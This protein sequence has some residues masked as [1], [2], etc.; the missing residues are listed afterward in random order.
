M[1]HSSSFSLPPPVSR[2]FI[3][4]GAP[5]PAFRFEHGPDRHCVT[6]AKAEILL[7]PRDQTARGELWADKS[8]LLGGGEEVRRGL[9]GRSPPISCFPARGGRAGQND[10][11]LGEFT[12]LCVDLDRAGML[13]DDDVMAERKTAAG[14]LSCGLRCEERAEHLGLHLREHA[15]AV[16]ADPDL[17]AIAQVSGPRQE[18]RLVSTAVSFV[19]AFHRRIKAVRYE[20]EKHSGNLLREEIDVASS[21]I[22]RPLQ[23]DIEPL[24]LGPCAVI[25]QIETFLDDGIYVD[26]PVL[27][28][29]CA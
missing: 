22:Q 7:Q 11:E 26:E 23:G 14:S 10:S 12:R 18:G 28:G 3:A 21:W 19:L 16:V 13:F 17:D 4:A 5:C 2:L 25:G 20:I 24:L 1:R 6:M 9:P 8:L 27:P 29:A 15:S